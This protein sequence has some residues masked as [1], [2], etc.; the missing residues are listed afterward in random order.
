M[1][2]R[3]ALAAYRLSALAYPRAFRARFGADML[4]LF[5][6]RVSVARTRGTGQAVAL[7]L[8]LY[9][10]A[11]ASGT[12][13]RVRTLAD[14][15]WW[16][17]HQPADHVSSSRRI[18]MSWESLRADLRL[19]GRQMRNAPLFAL[20][21]VATL[22]L[23]IGANGAIFAVLH[24]V[25]LRP[26][27]YDDPSRLVAIWSDNT[28]EQAPR[29][30]VSPAN[31]VAF[32][33]ELRSATSVEAMYSFL[34]NA[35][36][37]I[38]DAPEMVLS[39]SV[40]SGMFATLNRTP[41]LGR[42]LHAGDDNGVVL[43]HAFWQRRFNGDRNVVGRPI[44]V[45]G[46]PPATILGVMPEDF[47][48]PYRSMLGP[49]GFTRA[50]TPDIWQMLPTS[51]GRWV[52]TDGQPSRTIHY[53]TVIA[54]LA[55]GAT[56]DDARAEIGALAARRAQEF[57]DTNRGWGTTVVSLH[58]QTVGAVR[59]ALLLIAGGVG[60]VL[61]ITCINVANVLLA[62]AT[63]RQ[64]DL[65]IRSALGASRRRLVQQMLVES[66][67]LALAGGLVGLALLVAGTRALV[68][69]APAELPRV[70]EV[71]P[72]AL[73]I[74]FTLAVSVITGI[75]V[76]LLPALFSGRGPAADGLRDSHR[77]TASSAQRRLRS[78][79]IVAEVTLATVLTIGAA[80]LLRS[81]VA[82]MHVNPGFEPEQLLTFQMNVPARYQTAEARVDFYDQVLSALGAL[83][84]V[85][86][87][88]GSTRIPL[89]STQ[90]T[91]QLAVE[92]R[93]VP[94]ANLPEVEMRRAVG[95]YFRTMGIPVRSGRV[96]APADRAAA[97]GLAVIN[98]AL[99]ARIFPGEPA[100]GRR[101]RMGPNPDAAWLTII[102]V[103]GSIKHSNLE[104][105]PRPEIYITHY[106]G[107]PVSPFIAL[108]TSGDP[109]AIAGAAR[110]A[111]VSLGADPPYGVR[112]MTEL[113]RE[114]VGERRFV[115]T[116]VALFGVLALTLAGV[117]IYGVI[118]LVVS[119][120]TSE[121]G[122]RLALGATPAQVLGML[123]GQAVRL[124][125]TGVAIG[126]ALGLVLAQVA[127]TM[128]FGVGPAD[129][130]T[131]VLVPLLLLV[132]AAIA[133]LLPAR[134][135]MRIDPS[136]ALRQS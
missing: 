128:L 81:F 107:P 51:S 116:L 39:S 131:F 34:I 78:G 95:D 70:A 92:G 18:S 5:T 36:V 112:T 123:V 14:R 4:A 100:V 121:V 2:G 109:A 76:G 85:T 3:T 105:L 126:T 119:E 77:T 84:G 7:A 57:P 33:R 71:S 97:E 111:I 80:L 35:Q 83:P 98:D 31:F 42:T 117:G 96:F 62:R 125:A 21:T 38:D 41:L 50:Q 32:Q 129:P 25:L 90:V 75:V 114:S 26:L 69:L 24:A 135:A 118:A 56:A 127:A 48:F 120:R 43:S 67:V 16:P 87:V 79:L 27:P 89:G 28:R 58:D 106:Q 113:R 133:A 134:R 17:A 11:L 44:R 29:N 65:A 93:D 13:M 122:V 6:R 46:A 73:V 64:R 110:A 99:A 20:V 86:G 130:V 61:L 30:P 136:T 45:T 47:V 66:T 54:R 12:A 91:T 15:W 63:G 55:P 102:G 19:A 52:G 59:P 101:V 94:P 37:R 40:T 104:E 49:S 74:A 72:G 103:V 88:G 23:G 82:V 60:L 53:L 132:V 108:R 22:A 68:A 115:V 10:D 124:G 8:W 9:A 1:I